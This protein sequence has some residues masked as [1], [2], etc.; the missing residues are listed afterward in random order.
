MNSN[1]KSPNN[2]NSKN[3]RNDINDLE[4]KKINT[5]IEKKEMKNLIKNYSIKAKK[6]KEI[7]ESYQKLK[8]LVDSL[9]LNRITSATN[10]HTKNNNKTAEIM[11][12]IKKVNF[13]EINKNLKESNVQEKYNKITIPKKNCFKNHGSAKDI[14]KNFDFNRNKL[15]NKVID[16]KEDEFN[17]SFGSNSTNNLEE[18]CNININKNNH[19]NKIR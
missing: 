14:N 12:M 7:Y 2:N 16:R 13:V 18:E 3:D 1:N 5:I 6:Q 9:K 19:Q 8:H 17:S 10:F 11:M 15:E 4:M